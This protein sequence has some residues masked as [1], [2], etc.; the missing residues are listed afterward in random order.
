M[1]LNTIVEELS[2]YSLKC[3]VVVA[4]NNIGLGDSVIY[5][6]RSKDFEDLKKALLL[7]AT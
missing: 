6:K 4:N 1:V 7:F 2:T 5:K 3:L